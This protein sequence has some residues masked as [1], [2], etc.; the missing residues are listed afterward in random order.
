MKRKKTDKVI[1]DAIKLNKKD[2]LNNIFQLFE[3]YW[4][5]NSQIRQL[6]RAIT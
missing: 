6:I 4:C 2:W 5:Y 1:Y 3:G